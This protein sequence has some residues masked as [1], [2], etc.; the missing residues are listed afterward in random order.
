[1]FTKVKL[2]TC[3]SLVDALL[4]QNVDDLIRNTNASLK[5]HTKSTKVK[6]IKQIINNKQHTDPAPRNTNLASAGLVPATFHALIIPAAITA[7]VP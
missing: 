7:P 5:S 4:D 6:Q 3:G 2:T 1:L